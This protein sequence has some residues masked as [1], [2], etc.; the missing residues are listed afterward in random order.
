MN[1]TI[2]ISDL[3]GT[4]LS[5]NGRISEAT[6]EWISHWLKQDRHFIIATGRHYRNVIGYFDGLPRIPD[7][8]TSNGAMIND[9]LTLPIE[10][11]RINCLRQLIVLADF[12][13]VNFSVFTDAGWHV[14]EYNKTILSHDFRAIRTPPKQFV[15]LN[16][17]KGLFFGDPDKLLLLQNYLR[18]A[19]SDYVSVRSDERWLEFQ[20]KEINKFA[21][22]KKLL[23]ESKL[24]NK[25]TI[26]FGD[27][28]ND[29][30][31]LKGCTL[32]VVMDN[33]MPELKAILHGHP[34]TVSNDSE[35]VRIFLETF[36]S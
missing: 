12:H 14:T 25:K 21:A 15:N 19:F 13:E 2:I 16:A 30:E 4:L 28:L 27:G 8:I 29:V 11:C 33:A 22:L 7:L 23:K 26:A 34:I 17:F 20:W 24:E 18:E 32:G 9:K 10:K 5:S 6:L 1:N 36:F 3:D 35:G 31:L